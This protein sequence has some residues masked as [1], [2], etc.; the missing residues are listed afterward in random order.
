MLAQLRT[1]HLQKKILIVL[2][3]MIIPGF[4]AWGTASFVSS[5]KRS[6]VM[7]IAGEKIYQET[8]EKTKKDVRLSQFL[9]SRKDSYA[10]ADEETTNAFS[11]ERI[12]LLK[13]AARKKLTVA[14]TEV[15]GSIKALF[16]VNGTFRKGAYDNFLKMLYSNPRIRYSTQEFEEFLRNELLIAKLHELIFKD[17]R[18]DEQEV[19]EAL[20]RESKETKAD[21]KAAADSKETE[22]TYHRK[23]LIEKRM[24]AY[25]SYLQALAEEL[26]IKVYLPAK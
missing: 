21:K 24:R 12:I 18:V 11:I 22:E 1:Q 13:E 23:L 15:V 14:D 19:K 4:I 3:I 25:A 16:S 9:A 26:K 17:I 5:R 10:Q 7:E 8:F 20:A 2:T 6:P